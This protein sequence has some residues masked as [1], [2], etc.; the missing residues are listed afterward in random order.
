MEDLMIHIEDQVERLS[1][2]KEDLA[3]AAG[4]LRREN[5]RLRTQLSELTVQR[6]SLER[7]VR[8]SARRLEG[9]LA[10]LNHLSEDV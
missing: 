7:R 3:R 5:D 6:D 2:R 10:R 1:R 8:L 4:V 9:A